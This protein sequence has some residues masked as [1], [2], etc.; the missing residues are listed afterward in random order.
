MPGLNFELERAGRALTPWR[1]LAW[2]NKLT[3][4][5]APWL[6]ESWRPSCSPFQKAFA[7]AEIWTVMVTPIEL[8][9]NVGRLEAFRQEC[10]LGLSPQSTY[11]DVR[12]NTE[13][14]QNHQI[15]EQNELVSFFRNLQ[16]AKAGQSWGQGGDKLAKKKKTSESSGST[17]AWIQKIAFRPTLCGPE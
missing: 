10:A 4:V 1:R 15:Q 3:H 13:R 16:R 5:C 6:W 8:S 7:R 2:P 14:R 17:M 12:R 11:V 9:T